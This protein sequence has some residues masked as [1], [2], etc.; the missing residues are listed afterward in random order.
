MQVLCKQVIL[1]TWL[2]KIGLKYNKSGFP[3]VLWWCPQVD[4]EV[5]EYE[6]KFQLQNIQGQEIYVQN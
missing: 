4:N 3:K 2:I 1:N 5:K 6:R